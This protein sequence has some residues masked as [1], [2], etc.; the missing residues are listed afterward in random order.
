MQFLKILF[1]CLIAFIAALFTIGNW[2]TV[3]VRV[4]GGLIAE[5]NLP[6]LLLIVF[7][8]GFLPTLLY[9]QATKWRLRQRLAATER[10]LSEIRLAAGPPATSAMAPPLSPAGVPIPPVGEPRP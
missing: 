1:W 10:A 3:P 5:T 8:I 9:Q 4:G 2:T 6:L 7:L